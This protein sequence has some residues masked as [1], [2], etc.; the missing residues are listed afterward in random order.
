MRNLILLSAVSLPVAALA[1]TEP[2]DG[3]SNDE[4][5]EFEIES[6]LFRGE[7][8]DFGFQLRDFAGGE[9]YSA[10]ISVIV[11][12]RSDMTAAMEAL[13]AM[14]WPDT[15]TNSWKE[16]ERG[17]TVLLENSGL[18]ALR[19]QA[20]I[21]GSVLS[22]DLWDQ[23]LSWVEEIPLNAVLLGGARG[24]DSVNLTTIGDA[25][26]GLDRDLNFDLTE[27]M[28]LDPSTTAD[29]D[30]NI[31][32]RPVLEAVLTGERIQVRRSN[33]A[34]AGDVHSLSDEVEIPAP[35][36]GSSEVSIRPIWHGSFE[37]DMGLRFAIG[38]SAQFGS[39]NINIDPAY[40]YRLMLFDDELKSIQ[41]DNSLTVSH[42]LPSIRVSE[43]T[44]DFGRVI[45]GD[46]STVEVTVENHGNVELY[47][48]GWTEGDGFVMPDYNLLLARNN[49]GPPTRD[50]FEIDF[51]PT[52]LGEFSGTLYFHT[53][54]PTQPLLAIP[55]V[56][57][58]VDPADPGGDPNDPGDGSGLVTQEGR[59][60][61]CASVSPSGGL[62]ALALLGLVG[63]IA[64]RRRR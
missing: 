1:N 39:F 17:G 54:D 52:E 42:D 33:A 41:S 19:I 13:S 36:T 23:S 50:T 29:L 31:N 16:S 14:H 38:V 34:H 3:E 48:D 37:G 12:V 20:R 30:I 32:V 49:N 64:R 63:L 18:V 8:L 53:N 24:G 45:L 59:G 9:D 57:V 62:G 4:L 25:L 40:E 46:S 6:Q 44:L 56:G 22:Y 21:A 28:G 61:G 15:L 47:G 60:C 5:V 7:D 2:L 11:D 26:P 43:N 51:L 55:M 58:G 27:L 10:R 35:S